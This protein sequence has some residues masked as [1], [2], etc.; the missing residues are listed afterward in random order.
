LQISDIHISI[1]HDIKRISDLQ[2]FCDITVSAIQPSVVLATGDLTDAK[3]KDNIGSQQY[4][5]EWK[6]YRKVL[7]NCKGLKSSNIIW[8]DI[9]GNHGS[10]KSYMKHVKGPSG[11]VYSFIGLDAC[12]DQ[13]LRRPFNFIGLL[14][15]MEIE[16]LHQLAALSAS[17]ANY[18]VWFGHYPTSCILSKGSK[19]RDV[20]GKGGNSLAYLC[21]HLHTLGGFVPNMYTLQKQGFLELE[22]GDWKDNRMYRVAAID[23]GLLSFTDVH[24]KDWP[25]VLIT[26]PKHVLF[27]T[28]QRE[29]LYRMFRVLVFNLVP[30]LSVRVKLDD[31][32]WKECRKIGGP[33][34]VVKWEPR[35]FSKGVHYVYVSVTDSNGHEKIVE[36]PFSL[37]GTRLS[38]KL[39][40]RIFLMSNFSTLFQVMFGFSILGCVL[41]LC[42]LR[43]FNAQIKFR[44]I[45]VVK[46]GQKYFDLWLRR[47][48]VVANLDRFFYPLT[49]YPLY[50]TIGPWSVG[51]L[52]HGHV[53][54]LFAW[55]T[56]IN[57]TYLPGAFTYAYGFFELFLFQAPLILILGHKLY[58]R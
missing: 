48:W 18:T 2:E 13:G 6:K 51:E 57:G 16:H 37:D 40:P 14:S 58:S 42:I 25:V 36:Q 11:E 15:E 4:D 44:K 7:D 43:Y 35:Q 33:L 55:G 5:E 53:G 21:G 27:N 28:P 12:P 45:A 26:N 52:I 1:F 23:H 17:Q 10:V 49:L 24:H 30:L 34:Y 29:P 46:I 20:I 19:V 3:Q 32:D 8:L 47:L 54:V 31:G 50:L 39:L 56:F 41:P 22:L 38:F 9:R